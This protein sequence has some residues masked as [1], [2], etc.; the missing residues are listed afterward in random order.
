MKTLGI[1]EL[2]SIAGAE[3]R[4]VMEGGRQLDGSDIWG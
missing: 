3:P 1:E 2:S 4:G